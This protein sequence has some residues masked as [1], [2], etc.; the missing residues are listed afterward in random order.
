[1]EFHVSNLKFFFA[2]S[3]NPNEFYFLNKDKA[4]GDYLHY[5]LIFTKRIK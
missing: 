4:Y 1:M 5:N 3:S 2:E